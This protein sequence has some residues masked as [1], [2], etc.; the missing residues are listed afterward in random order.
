[1][2]LTSTLRGLGVLTMTLS[3]LSYAQAAPC[4]A[5]A[6]FVVLRGDDEQAATLATQLLAHLRAELHTRELGVCLDQPDGIAVVTLVHGEGTL[7]V[8]ID[9]HVT[10]K[11][12][13]RTLDLTHLPEDSRLLAV[14]T[15]IDELLRA[16]WL[17]TLVAPTAAPP[18]TPVARSVQETL[19]ARPVAVVTPRPVRG[20]LGIDVVTN[21]VPSLRLAFGA[22]VQGAYWLRQRVALLARVG[23]TTSVDERSFHGSIATSLWRAGV[24][25]GV[26]LL[27]AYQRIGI[28]PEARLDAGVVQFHARASAGGIVRAT[29]TL[30]TLGGS[31]GVRSWFD[32]MEH[33]PLR[34]H[35]G[36]SVG[37]ALVPAVG[38]DRTVLG[39]ERAVAGVRGLSLE[40]TL[41]A[42]LTLP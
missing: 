28:R 21:M 22:D 32:P 35:A 17:E 8:R 1:M 15:S 2:S 24:G 11:S 39:E 42:S 7:T 25:V 36:V 3:G 38:T 29:D 4:D 10:A 33:L 13:Q 9:D 16:S 27:P 23:G 37:Y 40:A 6:S 31:L 19:P 41:G 26:G 20:E 34:L 5:H 18:P 14:A 30:Q 12:V